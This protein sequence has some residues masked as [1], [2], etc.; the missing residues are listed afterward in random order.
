MPFSHI[1]RNLEN[2]EFCQFLLKE[3]KI[4]KFYLKMGETLNLPWNLTKSVKTWNLLSVKLRMTPNFWLS[5]NLDPYITAYY[6][7]I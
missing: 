7:T 3:G 4:L 2:L 5:R 1:P 6:V